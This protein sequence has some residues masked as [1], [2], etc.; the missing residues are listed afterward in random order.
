M[1]WLVLSLTSASAS[2]LHQPVDFDTQVMPILTKAGCNSGACHGAAA[3]RGGFR[4]S[5]YGSR[6]AT[7]FDQIALAMKGRRIDR[8]DASQSLFLLKPTEQ[9]SHEGG[10]R[11]QPESADHAILLNWISQGAQRT[12]RRTLD[13]FELHAE[14]RSDSTGPTYQISATACFSDGTTTDVLPWTVLTPDDPDSTH[15]QETGRIVLRTAG[16]H[17]VIARFLDQ[18]RP[19]E[20]IVPWQSHAAD[21]VEELSADTGQSIDRLVVKR[22]RQFGLEATS[23][24]DEYTLIRR[25]TL[26][27]TGCLPS[28]KSVKEFVSSSDVDKLEH[29]IESLLDS[30]E[31]NSYW[32]FQLAQ[33]LRVSALKAN[34]EWAR[35]YY[36]WIHNC[37]RTDIGLD[38][39]SRQ[40][41][42]AEGLVSETG[43]A[44]FYNIGGDP[45]GQAEFVASTMMGVR[46]Q[47]ANCHDHP[48]DS[49]T[50]DDYHGLA[51]IFARIK[52]GDVIRSAATGRVIHPGTGEPAI[53]RLPD[54]G[55]LGEDADGRTEFAEW[56]T[57]AE[58]P[59]FA[60]AMVNRLWRHMM[61]RGLVEPVDDHR[62]TNSPTNPE[63]MDGLAK[64]FRENDCQLRPTLRA[65]C[66][67]AAYRRSAVDHN[68]QSSETSEHR[69]QAVA[70]FHGAAISRPMS[71][72]VFLDAVLDVT[73]SDEFSGHQ[74]RAVS[75][76]GLVATSEPLDLLGRCSDACEQSALRRN[77][78]AVQLHLINGSFINQK[79][80]DSTAITAE[81]QACGRPEEFIAAIYL[82]VLSRPA[83]N[84]EMEFWLR[85]FGG[86]LKGPESTEIAQDFVWSLLNSTEFCTN[87]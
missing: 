49:W 45:R 2:I 3:G 20:F 58:N 65:I 33:L 23:E 51:A 31:F 87:H 18:V 8:L 24:A 5:L 38:Q 36:E 34:A 32:T 41:I 37:V 74:S 12:P 29:L 83:R 62:A 19:L 13:S 25:L 21:D 72:Q 55:F 30:D 7:D 28:P 48:L 52:S 4:L 64:M 10:T 85:Q 40:L 15:V 75:L 68:R 26:D 22:L 44:A 11:I 59:Y 78:L 77:D 73:Q 60:R 14:K 27:L 1:W 6:P 80:S 61:G 67:S 35:V 43:A 63:L 17:V 86:T 57:S 42:L 69:N 84:H 50:Q 39:M 81:M 82:R 79:L 66:Q 54:A 46:L 76:D 56:L 71:P 70:R 53:R 16:Q 9:L 47:C